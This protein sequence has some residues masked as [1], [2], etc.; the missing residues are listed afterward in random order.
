FDL[1]KKTAGIGRAAGQLL[2]VSML[3][4]LIGLAMPAGFQ[5]ILDEV[6]VA[7]DRDLLLTVTRGLAGL[8]VVQ[9]V[10]SCIRAWSM[11]VLCSSLTLRWRADLFGRLMHLPL[12]YFETRHVGDIVSRFGSL[13]EIQETLTTRALMG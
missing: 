11:L 8:L 9:S 3:L 10:L 6:V 2:A 5:I 12:D 1:L 4:E 7:W 13:D